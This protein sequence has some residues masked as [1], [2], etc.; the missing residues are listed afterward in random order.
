M[1]P[2]KSYPA[3]P[4]PAAA[5]QAPRLQALSSQRPTVL[6]LVSFTTTHPAAPYSRRRSPLRGLDW[7]E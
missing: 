3:S 2:P 7:P 4:A 5:T 1:G 6:L